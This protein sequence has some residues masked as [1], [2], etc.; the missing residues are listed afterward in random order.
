MG[1]LRYDKIHKNKNNRIINI[2]KILEVN[3]EI[4]NQEFK[5]DSVLVWRQ[6]VR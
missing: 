2:E 4:I 1:L 5:G 6:N 3:I